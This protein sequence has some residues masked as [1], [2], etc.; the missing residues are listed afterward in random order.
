MK[1]EPSENKYDIYLGRDV[2]IEIPGK[3]VFGTVDA[4]RGNTIY[5]KPSLV[6][7]NLQTTKKSEWE[8]CVFIE[9]EIPSMVELTFPCIISPLKKR[10]FRKIS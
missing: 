1:L 10:I 6:H 9:P 2:R 3:S 7:Q 5:L 8:Y 4:V